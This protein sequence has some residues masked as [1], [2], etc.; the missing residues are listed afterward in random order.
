MDVPVI[1]AK[2]LR[3]MVDLKFDQCPQE[4]WIHYNE[5]AGRLVIEFFGYH[6][7]APKVKISGT[8][9]I[10][11]LRVVNSETVFALNGKSSQVSMQIDKGWH[12]DSWIIGGKV[13]RIQLWMFLDPSRVLEAEKKRPFLPILIISIVTASITTGILLGLTTRK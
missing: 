7:D 2:T 8:T 3:V 4:Y 11:D 6:V 10:S 5:D 9:V 1:E 13:L 12:Y